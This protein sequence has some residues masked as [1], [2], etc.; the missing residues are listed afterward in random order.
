MLPLLVASVLSACDSDSPVA[1]MQT[2]ASAPP[3]QCTVSARGTSGCG[4]LWGLAMQPPTVAAVTTVEKELGRTFDF[5][6]R[7][8][9]LNDVIPDDAERQQ[10]REAKVLHIAIATRRFED[11]DRSRYQWRG[12]ADGM[13]DDHLE[14]QAKGIAALGVP[15]FVTFEQE[16]NQRRKREMLGS[17]RDFVAAWRHVHNLYRR[18]G[19]T[20]VIWTW[21]MTGSRRNLDAAARMWPGNQYVDWI[22]WNVYNQSGCTSGEIDPGKY[23]SFED[24]LRVFYD[25]VKRRGPGIGMDVHKP[26]MIS[27][28]GTAQYAGDLTRSADW[29]AAIPAALER[30]PQVKAV[31]LWD[32]INGACDYKF[33]GSPVVRAGVREAGLTLVKEGNRSQ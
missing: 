33:D 26:M 15:V 11:D 22:S 2:R 25:F 23:V 3:Q 7:Y 14:E 30:Y 4:V 20:N 29:Y 8:H 32:S 27:E 13:Y 24:K 21:V 16:A 28:A 31:G 10:V 9:D 18:A 6:Y 19:A 1:V 12:V 5:V 17:T